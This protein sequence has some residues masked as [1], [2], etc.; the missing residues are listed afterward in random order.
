MIQLKVETATLDKLS[1]VIEYYNDIIDNQPSDT[2]SAGFTKD[3]YPSRE[4]LKKHILNHDLYIGL[5]DGNIVTCGVL[6]YG[7]EDM[8]RQGNWTIEA[9]DEETAILHLFAVKKEYRG[10][11]I[12][13]Q[14]LKE[15][16]SI[17]GKKARVMHLD[18]MIGNLS[19][20]RLYL[21]NGFTYGGRVKVYY[22]DTGETE[23]DLFE[24][25]L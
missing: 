21:R 1:E 4:L 6:T 5:I 24:K 7:E 23:A 9:S 18:I 19:A 11:G 12:S 14:M 10:K 15:L 2:Y 16:L 22:E 17:A 20:E 13:N 8:Y 25:K 3:I